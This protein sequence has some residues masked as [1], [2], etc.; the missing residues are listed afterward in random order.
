MIAS[1]VGQL[2]LPLVPELGEA[3]HEQYQRPRACR[4][5]VQPQAV[6]KIC[7]RVLEV[8]GHVCERRLVCHAFPVT[9]SLSRILCHAFPIIPSIAAP[10]GAEPNKFC[11]PS[12]TS[13]VPV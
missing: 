3:M 7:E 13:T 10:K 2:L 4:N 12:T 5:I 9:V 1:E 11:P 8:E 6:R